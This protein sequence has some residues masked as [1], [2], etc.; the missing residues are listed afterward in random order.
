MKAHRSFSQVE[1]FAIIAILALV[2]AIAV[3]TFFK[4][5]S[6]ISR[7]VLGKSEEILNDI[8]SRWMLLGGTLDWQKAGALGDPKKDASCV[9]YVL[10]W[11]FERGHNGAFSWGNS[12][13]RNDDGGVMTDSYGETGSWTVQLDPSVVRTSLQAMATRGEPDRVV[14]EMVDGIYY[15]D[16]KNRLTRQ[17]FYKIG[18]NAYVI[19]FEPTNIGGNKRKGFWIDIDHPVPLPR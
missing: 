1:L 11:L 10:G 8:Y 17:C 5:R 2:V 19:Y 13:M 6:A 4:A 14:S 18:Q 9:C 7:M 3:P 16:V 15:G 12:R